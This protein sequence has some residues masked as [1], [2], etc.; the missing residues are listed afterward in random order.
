[1]SRTVSQAA[2][3]PSVISSSIVPLIALTSTQLSAHASSFIL[4]EILRR[5]DSSAA[6]EERA[7]LAVPASWGAV[8]R[9]GMLRCNSSSGTGC[10]GRLAGLVAFASE[11]EHA[12]DIPL[13]A[14]VSGTQAGRGS[15]IDRPG[16]SASGKEDKQEQMA[17]S[18]GSWGRSSCR[19]ASLGRSE[20]LD[21]RARTPGRGQAR[22]GCRCWSLASVCENCSLVMIDWL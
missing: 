14:P 6:L 16:S 18:E 4:D 15:V 5:A 10:A 21:G 17:S 9:P 22:R 8:A 20:A 3:Y 11:A 7:A 2:L 12:A 13:E 1:M 19:A